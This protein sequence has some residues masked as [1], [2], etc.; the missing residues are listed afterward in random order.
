M[1]P[2]RQVVI[3][4][5]GPG[6]SSGWQVEFTLDEDT[7]DRLRQLCS[8]VPVVA[9][10]I[11]QRDLII[12]KVRARLRKAE[13]R[14][15]HEQPGENVFDASS[16]VFSADGTFSCVARHRGTNQKVQ[17]RAVDVARILRLHDQLPTTLP[18]VIGHRTWSPPCD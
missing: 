12:D 14:V 3:E 1:K 6:R 5:V 8:L 13:W 15:P 11:R 7:A 2:R 10:S 9:P 17:T 18:I 16:I 4:A